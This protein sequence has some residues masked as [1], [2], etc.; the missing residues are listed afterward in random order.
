[1]CLFPKTLACPQQQLTVSN[2]LQVSSPL[3]ILH[4]AADKVTDPN[5]NKFL[6]EKDASKDKTL[7]LYDGSY[8]CILEGES[9]KR[10]FEVF[11]DIIV[12]ID[13][14]CMIR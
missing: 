6:Y 11:D 9:A 2:N 7:N 8:C 10:I 14:H 13:A 4:G 5:I 12:W 3:L 1:M